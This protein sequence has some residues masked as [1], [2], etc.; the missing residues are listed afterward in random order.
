MEDKETREEETGGVDNL[1]DKLGFMSKLFAPARLLIKLH[2][3]VAYNEFKK[4]SERFT[5]GIFQIFL[6]LFF[7]IGFL[8]LLNVLI[9][10]ALYQ[11][12]FAGENIFF[13][14]LITTGLN[15]LVSLIFFGSAK[16][17]FKTK[18]FDKTR[19]LLKETVEELSE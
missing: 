19:Q 2:M 8:I 6:G 7:L 11:F 13:P 9:V 10:T 15:L 12:L 14:V 18:F 1:V 5:A 4:D 17:S 3:K 16:S